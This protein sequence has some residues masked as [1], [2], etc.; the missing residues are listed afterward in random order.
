ARAE[1]LPDRLAHCPV[2]EAWADPWLEPEAFRSAERA[3]AERLREPVAAALR[4]EEQ[5][6][7]EER[8]EQAAAP[9]APR[10]RKFRPSS[11]RAVARRCATRTRR[12]STSTCTTRTACST[13]A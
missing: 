10:S 4:L 2:S 9:R 7:L 5:A 1:R 8:A 6:E 3:P 11:A 13:R 12:V